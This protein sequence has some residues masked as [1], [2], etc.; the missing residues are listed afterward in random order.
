LTAAIDWYGEITA[1]T[2]YL[3]TQG[4]RL[5]IGD[6]LRI[7]T[8]VERLK[9]ERIA[10]DSA[11]AAACWFA[12]VTCRTAD[13]QNRL[14]GLLTAWA[15][16]RLDAKPMPAPVPPVIVPVLRET[17]LVE[18][19]R[20]RDWYWLV[21]V[22]VIVFALGAA[23]VLLA[24][25]I[26]YPLPAPDFETPTGYTPKPDAW[27][28]VADRLVAGLAVLVP[29]VLVLFL[30][31]DR[32]VRRAAAL[33]GLVPRDAPT[34]ALN[35]KID[36]LSLFRPEALRGGIGDLRRFRMMPAEWI[37]GPR[38]VAATVAAGGHVRLVQ[39]LRPM[40]P[41]HLLLVDLA[42]ADDILAVVAELMVA[43]LR[44]SDVPVER[45]D[46]QGDPRRLRRIGKDGLVVD[47]IELDALHTLCPDH[48]LIVLSDATSFSEAGSERMRSWVEELRAWSDRAVLTPL[49]A[50][51][52]G[53][54]E[55]A[56]IRLGFNVATATP[57]GIGELAR[58]FRVDLPQERATPGAAL[59]PRF[60][61][62]MFANPYRWL[63]DRSPEPTDIALLVS[64]LRE[65][66]GRDG[67]LYLAA[68][69]VFPAIHVKLTLALGRVL[70]DLG[71]HSVL[72]EESLSLLCRVPWL[73][74]GRF[75][76]W[77]RLALVR[78]LR[79]RPDEAE[80]VRIAW[81]TLLEPSPEPEATTLPI[82]VVRQVEP[83]L[84][85]LIG[86]LLKRSGPY[87]EAILIAFLNREELPELAVELPQRLAQ[88][89][90][91]TIAWADVALSVVGLATS[92]LVASLL[93]TVGG[94]TVALERRFLT[95]QQIFGLEKGLQLSGF[96]AAVIAL[97]LWYARLIPAAWWMRASI[98]LPGI[99]LT[100]SVRKP[101]TNDASW[102]RLAIIAAGT[103]LTAFLAASLFP[104]SGQQSF[105]FVL[106]AGTLAAW[107]CE[108]SAP[109]AIS[110]S[111]IL[112]ALSLFVSTP[113]I[114][115]GQLYLPIVV[116]GAWLGCRYPWSELKRMLYYVSPALL[117]N[118]PLGGQLS[119][120]DNTGILVGLFL[121][122]RFF[123]DPNYREQCLTANTLTWLNCALL[124]LPLGINAGTMVVPNSNRLGI[125]WDAGV[126][127]LLAFFLIGLSR[128]PIK[129]VLYGVGPPIILLSFVF[130]YTRDPHSEMFF[131]NYLFS[132]PWEMIGVI[133][134]FSS[135]FIL[136][137]FPRQFSFEQKW[138]ICGLTLLSYFGAA[139]EIS[140]PFEFSGL[141]CDPY[142]TLLAVAAAAIV[143]RSRIFWIVG[144]GLIAYAA[145]RAASVL[146]GP[147]FGMLSTARPES[148]FDVGFSLVNI[149]MAT[150]GCA[151]L[152]RGAV[153]KSQDILRPEGASE[154]PA[155][156]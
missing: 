123:S 101:S 48:R 12:P 152:T 92:V 85:Q 22:V 132:T 142:A 146:R 23:L 75:P 58:Q 94:A 10:I 35:I 87:R 24:R 62:L 70:N 53:P 133:V 83:G 18:R 153:V 77:L 131:V 29:F 129:R 19:E 139:V 55:R 110:W 149:G 78:D 30:R 151:L 111:P 144:S 6:D 150:I 91:R 3:H 106:L 141:V 86:G 128:I 154:L 104:Y 21:A 41:E 79:S 68:L 42:G 97:S 145:I 156:A 69:A 120:P 134:A 2:S 26:P 27:P 65:V 51:Q 109:S 5:T 84:P 96:A 112:V 137:S 11:E 89:L 95:P 114:G 74:R 54:R 117:F 31:Y 32:R 72:T 80:T 20:K 16:M 108:K 130:H 45:F 37:D 140:G 119:L 126:P 155:A 136:R 122:S 8:L 115:W 105:S 4:I 81:A 99:Q 71:G 28:G 52:W 64:E 88:L 38:S 93:E 148:W 76:D 36:T 121:L 47:H 57:D 127:L 116:V 43:R 138:T 33:R 34:E 73:R 103:S 39:G 15:G 13:E 59:P 125:Q 44:E 102:R 63:G 67:F 56:L 66:L 118:L 135:G 50:W 9:A 60:D 61:R 17:R 82:D 124:V 147:D 7:A 14:V 25:Y 113:A 107:C 100:V 143:F 46:Y 40:R 49:P 98:K 90:R 1:W